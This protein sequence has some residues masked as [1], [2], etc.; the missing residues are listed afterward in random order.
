MYQ[1]ISQSSNPIE[2][3]K[4]MMGNNQNEYNQIMTIW[5]NSGGNLQKAM[6]QLALQRGID[7]SGI[8]QMINTLKNICL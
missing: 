5:N 7:Q 3:L 4:S 1:K 2:V 8:G 6:T